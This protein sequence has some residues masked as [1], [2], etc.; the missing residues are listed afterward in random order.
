MQDRKEDAKRRRKPSLGVPLQ[1]DTQ[2]KEEKLQAAAREVAREV[3]LQD[4]PCPRP[5]PGRVNA[6]IVGGRGGSS[7]QP[8]AR[9]QASAAS[10][11]RKLGFVPPKRTR[12]GIGIT[13][14]HLNARYAH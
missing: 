4:L 12:A 3:Q 14:R 13:H 7:P 8:L 11:T 9:L 10:S 2:N 5:A 6:A 1:Q